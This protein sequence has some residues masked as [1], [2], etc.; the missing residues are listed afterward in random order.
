MRTYSILLVDD[1]DFAIRGIEQGVEWAKIRI[2]KVY[3]AHTVGSAIRMLESMQIDI[4][5]TDIEMPNG[6]G[7]E[8]ISWIKQNMPDTI[9]IFYTCHAEFSYAQKAVQ[10]GV[11]DYLL[12]P[13]PYAEL[14]KI[15]QRAVS[16]IEQKNKEKKMMEV[17]QEEIPESETETVVENVKSYILEHISEDLHRDEIAKAFFLNPDYL[18]RIFKKKEQMTIVAYITMKRMTLAKKLLEFTNLTITEIGCRVGIPDISYFIKKF[19][20]VYDMTPQ[21]FR[22]EIKYQ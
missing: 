16:L 7:L 21:Q 11:L 1:E 20:A 9:C 6:T 19:K 13:V 18:A 17:Y 3:K 12:K 4:V 15:L 14:E 10:L 5:L 22:N 2:S 8:L